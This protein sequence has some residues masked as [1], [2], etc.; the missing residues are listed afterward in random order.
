M[1]SV[2][3]AFVPSALGRAAACGAAFAIATAPGCDSSSP[4]RGSPDDAVDGGTRATVD[5]LVAAD[6]GNGRCVATN[7]HGQVVGVADDDTTFLVAAD[8][9]R[10][11]LKPPD[12]STVVTGIA[13][14]DAGH[15]SGY[16][17]TAS[18]RYAAV[19]QNAAW[20]PLGSSSGHSEAMTASTDGAIGGATFASSGTPHAFLLVG[21]STI[22]FDGPAGG[23]AVYA[24]GGGNRAAGVVQ[25][26]AGAGHAFVSTGS[27]WTDLGTFGGPASAAL[28]MNT[29]GDVVGSAQTASGAR[30]AFFVK[31]GTK[32]LVD[33]GLPPGTVTSD[34]RGVDLGGHIAGNAQASD[35]TTSA[36]LFQVGQSP[37]PL[38]AMGAGNATYIGVHA[39]AISS[40]GRI[41]GWGVS[42]PTDAGSALHCLEW[43]VRK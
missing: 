1:Q 34:A 5:G 14:D 18:T 17:T 10:T 13:I 26:T 29:R 19:Y 4:T 11:T 32:A 16:A 7:G 43:T 25:T 9:T 40:D 33:L 23:S 3:G 2:R 28:G 36:W 12:G 6:L 27:A 20:S 22:S 30:H 38:K 41:V 21:G 42:P 37:I 8:G 35:G 15:V 39:A 31:A 24:A